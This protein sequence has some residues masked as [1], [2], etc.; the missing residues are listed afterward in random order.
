MESILKQ[1]EEEKRT[2]Q[3]IPD[4]L[5]KAVK[6]KKF[7]KSNQTVKNNPII[8]LTL[9]KLGNVLD[10]SMFMD[11][12]KQNDKIYIYMYICICIYVYTTL[13]KVQ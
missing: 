2:R 12:L 13:I 4:G 10:I 1:N 3:T 11:I 6:R 8:T 7:F 9:K 5:K